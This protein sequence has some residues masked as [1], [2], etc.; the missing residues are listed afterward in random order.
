MTGGPERARGV[1]RGLADVGFTQM[2]TPRLVGCLYV[3]AA[4]FIAVGSLVGL[5]LV[6]SVAAWAGGGWWWL[7]PLMLAAGVAGVLVVRIACEWV[8]MA[9]T[10][11]RPV[12]SPPSPV[13]ADKPATARAEPL[14]AAQ[15]RRTPPPVSRSRAPFPPPAAR[16]MNPPSPQQWPRQRHGGSGDA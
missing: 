10:R 13:Q 5:L 15:Q 9:F 4:G 12:Q 8:L 2:V 1:L 16:P 7:A 6:W 11:G 14:R 3:A